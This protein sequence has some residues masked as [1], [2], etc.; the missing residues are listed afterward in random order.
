MDNNIINYLKTNEEK[1]LPAELAV[2]ITPE[3]ELHAK[4][5]L[6]SHKSTIEAVNHLKIKIFE[7][8]LILRQIKN[9]MPPRSGFLEYVKIRIGIPDRTVQRY[10]NQSFE[11]QKR[12]PSIAQYSIDDLVS[13]YNLIKH[14]EEFL[15]EFA[16]CFIDTQTVNSVSDTITEDKNSLVVINENTG[17]IEEVE[18][19]LTERR[20]EQSLFEFEQ[21]VENKMLYDVE[22]TVTDERM[23]MLDEQKR[24]A[25]ADR[26][27]GAYRTV[28]DTLNK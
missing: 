14:D 17:E 27:Y 5:A 26:L 20:Y 21:F 25:L 22:K 9:L 19:S 12:M 23:L 2:V 4:R 6:Q 24:H 11:W 16:A 28:S 1:Q 18:D 8:G 3:I 7:T 13:K 10:M 15:A